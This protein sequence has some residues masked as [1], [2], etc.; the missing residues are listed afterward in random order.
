VKSK[1]QEIQEG[2]LKKQITSESV[3]IKAQS[4]AVFKDT[5]VPV[6]KLHFTLH[7]FHLPD[8]DHL[9]K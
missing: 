8:K 6:A 5:F 1:V 9:L 4:G 2:M 7:V 3:K